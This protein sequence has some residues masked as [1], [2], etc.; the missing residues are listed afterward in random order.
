VADEQQ[1]PA[2]G[3]TARPA[4]DGQTD[5]PQ[6]KDDFWHTLDRAI[7]N[8][9]DVTVATLIT[10][11]KVSVDNRGRLTDVTT[12]TTDIPAIITNVN[13]VD[14]NVTT[15]VA[16]SLKDDDSLKT[17]H[18]GLVD[19]AVTVLPDNI[20]ALAGLIESFFGKAKS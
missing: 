4:F 18:Q 2:D 1:A 12:P 9:A 17:F 5:Q 16:D 19:Q 20:K 11:V 10:D 15:E 3:G 13:L 14:G 7:S 8:L 6:T